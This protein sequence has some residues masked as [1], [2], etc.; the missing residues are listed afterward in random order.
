MKSYGD[1]VLLYGVDTYYCRLIAKDANLM[2]TFAD[3]ETKRF[4]QMTRKDPAR[5]PMWMEYQYR[6]KHVDEKRNE[7][8][9]FEFEKRS[10]TVAYLALHTFDLDDLEQDELRRIF[11]NLVAD[12]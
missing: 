8:K 2:V 6:Q 4:E 10:D 7:K 9:H 11:A 12:R 5:E 1:Y 3:G